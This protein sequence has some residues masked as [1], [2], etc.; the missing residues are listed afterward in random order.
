MRNE[1]YQE[2]FIC[3]SELQISLICLAPCIL[4]MSVIKSIWAQED[5]VSHLGLRYTNNTRY[6]SRANLSSACPD[7]KLYETEL[8]T[9]GT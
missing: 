3:T 2:N 5:P 1:L 7:E 9:G 4:G 8:P 6:G